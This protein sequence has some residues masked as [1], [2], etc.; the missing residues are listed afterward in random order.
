MSSS[1]SRVR[2]YSGSGPRPDH[3]ECKQREAKERDAAWR[4]LTFEQQLIALNDRPGQC[5]R[6]RQRIVERQARLARAPKETESTE[7]VAPR[8]EKPSRQD[9]NKR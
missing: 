1:H 6:Q 3:N 5:E 2:K 7:K 8:V 9:K 4:K